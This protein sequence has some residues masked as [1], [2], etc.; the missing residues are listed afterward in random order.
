MA[1]SDY[2]TTPSLNTTISGIDI[3]EGCPARNMN[4][5]V[6]Q[7]M[8]DVKAD[9]SIST[10]MQPVVGAAD[11]TTARTLFGARPV[12][13]TGNTTVYVSPTGNDSTGD[14]TQSAPWLTRQK[15]W[16]TI[17]DTFDLNGFTVTIQHADG[18]YT[19]GPVCKG[20]MIGAKEADSVI[21]QGNAATP[22]NVVSTQLFFQ[23]ARANVKNMKLD[24]TSYGIIL[25]NGAIVRLSEGIIFGACTTAHMAAS[26]YSL[27]FFGNSYQIVGGSVY[28]MR[29]AGAGGT[30]RA[31]SSGIV[32]TLTGTPAIGEFASVI[33]GG[34]IYASSSV[35]TYSGAAT[36][37]R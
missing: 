5:A 34:S 28:H 4:D 14:G 20:I 31:A 33:D 24:N 7:L 10:A 25:Q 22:A 19:D 11:L 37:K 36:G 29:S 30:I 9:A 16:D 6:R 17:R 32:V 2:S 21:F 12:R 8:A 1:I 3:G 23:E 13:L 18:T 26:S 15:A 27:L 35:V